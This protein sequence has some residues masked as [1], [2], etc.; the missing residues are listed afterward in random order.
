MLLAV[1]VSANDPTQ[2]P[3]WLSGKK[4]SPAKKVEQSK[5]ELQQIMIHPDGNRVVINGQ[6]LKAGDRITGARVAAI[7]KH[8][9][10]LIASQKRLTL[11]LMNNK[12][13]SIVPASGR[14]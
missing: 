14:K 13:V 5:F 12:Q 11:S 2:P 8:S 6:L 10:V 4:A 9:V 7:S 3:G 1:N